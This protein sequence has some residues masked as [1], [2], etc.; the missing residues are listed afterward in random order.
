MARVLIV[1]DAAFM[2]GTLKIMLER[3][4]YEIVGEANNGEEAIEKFKELKPDIVTLDI[5][6]PRMDGISALKNIVQINR[7]AKIIMVSAMGQ[8]SLVKEAVINGAKGFVVKPFKED[9]VIK[10]LEKFK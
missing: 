8:E 3:N 9:T 2:R 10:A 6:M 4:G 5:T 7:N 1:D